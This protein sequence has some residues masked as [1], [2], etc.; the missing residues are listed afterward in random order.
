MK[1]LKISLLFAALVVL[2][3]PVMVVLV[4]CDNKGGGGT[5]EREIIVDLK[6][7]YGTYNLLGSARDNQA[8]I[9]WNR[10]F[11]TDDAPLTEVKVWT[12]KFNGEA[13]DDTHEKFREESSQI[14]SD[15]SGGRKAT[16]HGLDFLTEYEISV[17]AYNEQGAF[18]K[19]ATII[20]EV[21]HTV[22]GNAASVSGQAYR[23]NTTGNGMMWTVT[24][25]NRF[26]WNLPEYTGGLP[27]TEIKVQLSVVG[28]D[29]WVTLPATATSFDIV[30]YR[31]GS[32]LTDVQ[33]A[34]SARLRVVFVNEVG[35]SM[36][37]M[38][39]NNP[40]TRNT[41]ISDFQG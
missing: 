5:S 30:S 33:S 19:V 16:W 17:Q 9:S 3:V 27:I 2:V 34:S 31:T 37:A 8:T 29:T 1:K 11:R 36:V 6:V 14:Y 20:V 10:A 32:N 39:S 15:G 35:E 41:P 24:W 18:G 26:T 13:I 23:T 25:Q 38:N 28:A 7:E 22:P 12:S 4:A 21:P 40:F